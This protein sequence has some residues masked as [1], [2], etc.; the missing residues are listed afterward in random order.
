MP[1][2]DCFLVGHNELSIAQS[3]RMLLYMYGKDSHEFRDRAKY[4][5]SQISI[6]NH[7]LT[8]TEV[9][10]HVRR[11]PGGDDGPG[12][13]SIITES[14]NL[15]VACLGSHLQRNGLTFDFLN[16]FKEERERLAQ[17]LTEGV[18]CV[19][20][21]TTFYLS[22]HPIHE[23]IS[24]IRQ[25]DRDVKI[26]VGGPYVINK[27]NSMSAEKIGRLFETI[28]A[29]YYVKDSFGEDILVDL[30]KCIVAGVEPADVRNVYYRKDGR[31][32]ECSR[33][34]VKPY[35]F[36]QTPV[37]WNLFA[38]R[39][40]RV[41]NVRTAVSCPYKCAFCNYPAY[42]G[43]YTLSPISE[44]ERELRMLK[45]CGVS[46]IQFVDD[47][48]NVPKKRFKELLQ[49]MIRNKFGFRWNSYFKC[50]YVDAETIAL[51]KESG[52]EFVFLGIE[53]GSQ[54][55]LDNM[56][57]GTTVEIYRRCIELFREHDIMT[58]CS[59]IVGFP[60][61]TAETFQE[62]YEFVEDARPT[63]F[64]QRLWWYDHTAPIHREADTY[65]I[66]GSG[67]EWTH[68]SMRSEEAHGL[69]D[70]LFMNINGSTHITEYVLP[71]FLLERGVDRTRTVQFLR[72][73]MYANRDQYVRPGTQT[74]LQYLDGI[75]GALGRSREPTV[76]MM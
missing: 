73:Y 13:L 37:D 31:A 61:E 6:G 41:V 62:T 19:A 27:L 21:I 54:R 66:Q 50:Q 58:M 63:F 30:V 22:H 40:T 39:L 72:N 1:A 4:T 49:M 26:I 36:T 70:R 48:F 25:Y 34:Q 76:T 20:I 7:R 71:F 68:A 74:N 24:F 33:A 28:G 44:C 18:R 10:N 14:F 15:A 38:S 46:Y 12:D 16:G 65:Q 69:A 9:Y 75:Y 56:H 53:S 55:I 5:M 29:D 59:L 42:A 35:D 8:P 67:Y 17:S 51:M 2:T 60:G 3:K 52:C 23:I 47:T 45:D 64:Q 57:K 43:K 11:A 32:F